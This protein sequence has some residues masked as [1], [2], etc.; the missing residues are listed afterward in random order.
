MS[1]KDGNIVPQI[2]GNIVPHN[3]SVTIIGWT[4]KAYEYVLHGFTYE[5]Q[6]VLIKGEGNLQ[7]YTNENTKSKPVLPT[8]N[9]Q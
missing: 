3:Q 1:N 7:I 2:K 5:L 6:Y 8:S 4:S 9:D